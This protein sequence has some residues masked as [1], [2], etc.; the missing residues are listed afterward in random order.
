MV[1]AMNKFG[2]LCGIVMIGCLYLKGI[3]QNPAPPIAQNPPLPEEVVL[4]QKY[5]SINTSNPPGDVSKA[6]EFFQQILEKEGIPVELLWTRKD[7]GRVN[8]LARLKGNGKKRPIVLLNHMDVV[9]VNLAGWTVNPFGGVIKNEYI[10]GRGALDMKNNGIAQL[11]TL[12]QLKRNNIPLERDVIL[13]AVCDEETGGTTGASWIAR[14][15][16]NEINAEYILDEGGFGTQGFFTNDNR[17]IFSVGVAEKRSNAIKL[18]VRG[19]GGHGSMPPKDNPNFILAQ[20]LARIAEYQT[21]EQIT[22]V[23]AE[24]IKRLGK[25]DDT[26]YNNALKR[27]TI[28][29]TVLKGFVGDPPK[30]NVIPDRA[31]ATLD[32]R[33][34][35]GQNY[36]LFLAELRKVINDPRVTLPTPRQTATRTV[37]GELDS[38]IVSPF[39]TELFRII[40]NETKK[41]YPES[42]T[43]PHLVIYATDSRLFRPKGAICY[44][45]FPGPVTIDE[46][47]TIHAND[48]RIRVESFIT[49][50]KIYYNVVME[51][52]REK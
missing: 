39:N 41:V 8:V 50:V 13:L 25:L 29:L 33:L 35:P 10:Y 4:F 44:G 12:I 28:S 18:T 23:A 14:N 36:N 21:P 34:L 19:T 15:K 11:M 47:R 40:E 22:P 16:W 43:L 51:L 52:C 1:S 42:I 30:T 37:E 45:F 5:L 24:M 27:N 26:P 48:E 38:S 2:L 49:A 31:E 7:S 6:G 9:P 20:A 17:L 32:C 46:Y 3:A